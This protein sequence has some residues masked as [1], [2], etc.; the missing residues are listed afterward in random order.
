MLKSTDQSGAIHGVQIP[1][2]H[3]CNGFICE[4]IQ[5]LYKSSGALIRDFREGLYLS[6]ISSPAVLVCRIQGCGVVL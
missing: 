6:K 5:S 3:E 1:I 2:R 4:N